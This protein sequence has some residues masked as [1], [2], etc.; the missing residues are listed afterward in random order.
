MAYVQRN[1]SGDIV[2][3]YGCPQPQPDGSCLTDPEPL[4]D[5]HPDVVAYVQR[6]VPAK[7]SI[8]DGDLAALLVKEGVIPQ[9]V[10][11]AAIAKVDP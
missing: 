9:S 1:S 2:G 3:V 5:D 7:K 8:S 11:D 4:P 6:T 10:V